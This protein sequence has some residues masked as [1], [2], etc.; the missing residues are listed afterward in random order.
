MIP[1]P[2]GVTFQGADGYSFSMRVLRGHNSTHNIFLIFWRKELLLI[3]FLKIWIGERGPISAKISKIYI[4]LFPLPMAF[5]ILSL[6]NTSLKFEY[7]FPL[8][9]LMPLE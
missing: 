7:K 1:F 9:L 3:L 6:V 4:C 2:N 8:K 5:A